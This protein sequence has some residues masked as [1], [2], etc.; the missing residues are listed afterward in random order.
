MAEIRE[1]RSPLGKTIVI[2]LLVVITVL[3]LIPLLYIVNTAFRPWNVIKEYPPRVIFQ[4]SIGSFLRIF[5]ART[6]YAPGT[7][8][9]AQ[10][11]AQMKWYERYIYRETNEEVVRLGDLPQRYLN[12]LI[13][14]SLSTVLTIILGTLTAYAFSRFKVRGKNDLLFFILST[15]MLPPVVVVIPIFLMFRFVSLT[16]THIGLIL[17]YTAFNV[18]FAVWVLKGFIDEIPTE[19]EEAA[20]VDGYTRFQVF[21]KIVLPQA[22]TG[23]AATAVFCFLFAWN[24]YG[25]AFLLSRRN[26]QT[27]P[28]WLPYQMGVL[29]YDWGAAAAGTFLFI[30]PAVVFTIILRKHLVRGISFGAIRK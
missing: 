27:V 16:D 30:L 29:G 3:Y 10:K 24:E 4:P 7:A 2:V 22:T 19:Y 5:T 28:A 20:M 25:F 21:R 23:I 9:D 17:L 11:L 8:P 12:S 13:V 6:V 1:Q 14:G 18:S 15:R 26:A